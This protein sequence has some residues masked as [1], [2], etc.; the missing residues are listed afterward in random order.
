[1]DEPEI[2]Y[3]W[4]RTLMRLEVLGLSTI[5]CIAGL[6]WYYGR[7]NN[8]ISIFVIGLLAARLG[9][10]NCVVN[11]VLLTM[12]ENPYKSPLSELTID[13]KRESRL[14]WIVLPAIAGGFLGQVFLADYVRGPGDPFGKSIS[15]GLVV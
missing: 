13:T 3:R 1:M 14:K 9:I 5:S 6:A 12:P 10:C 11:S 15:F 7:P 8:A 4:L 2:P